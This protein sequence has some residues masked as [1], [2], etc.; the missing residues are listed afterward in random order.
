M[1]KRKLITI[2][3]VF[4]LIKIAEAKNDYILV[5]TLWNIYHCL[6]R[7][8]I[9]ENKIYGNYCKHRFCTYCSGIRKAEYINKYYETISKWHDIHFLTLTSSS[10]PAYLLEETIN[11][12][13]KNFTTIKDRLKKRHQRGTGIKP[14]GLRSLECNFNPIKRTYNPHYHILVPSYEIAYLLRY[15][16]MKVWGKKYTNIEGQH[17]VKVDNVDSKL[18]ELIKYGAKIISRP[19]GSKI[20]RKVY[21]AALYNIISAMQGHRLFCSFGFRLPQKAQIKT[22]QKLA[23]DYEE[24]MYSTQ[25][26]DWIDVN[27]GNPLT[28]FTPSSYLENKLNNMDLKLE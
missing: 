15:E 24:L 21:I 9:S 23:I 13:I 12:N 25:D 2:K 27:N 18:I 8:V 20:S 19:K 10:C 16:W 14:L 22:P 11:K 7:I 17:I 4:E 1:A 28:G 26:N 3:I 5:H 6:E